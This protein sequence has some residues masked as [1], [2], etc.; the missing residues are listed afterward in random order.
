MLRYAHRGRF[1]DRLTV[2]LAVLCAFALLVPAAYAVQQG[3][4]KVTIEPAPARLPV[5]GKMTLAA[6]ASYATAPVSV[7]GRFVADSS[8]IRRVGEV[9]VDEDNELRYVAF[10]NGEPRS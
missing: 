10:Y 5:G 6:K 8:D 9:R 2:A 4:A 3:P 7:D 1:A